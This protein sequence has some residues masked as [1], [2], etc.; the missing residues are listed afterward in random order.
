M[1]P[2]VSEPTVRS[3]AIRLMKPPFLLRRASRIAANDI[4]R[5]NPG[6]EQEENAGA[7]T[8]VIDSCRC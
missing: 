3:T 8:S 5:G 6:A 1:T 4:S 2:P 7:S